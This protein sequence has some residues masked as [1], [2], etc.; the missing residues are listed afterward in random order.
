M[1][2]DESIFTRNKDLSKSNEAQT[3][4]PR[5]EIF[6]RKELFEGDKTVEINTY[7]S[8]T[9]RRLSEDF[10]NTRSIKD[11]LKSLEQ[12]FDQAS[13]NSDKDDIQVSVKQRLQNFMKLNDADN[14][15][16]NANKARPK[17]NSTY[18]LEKSS[19]TP[20]FDINTKDWSSIN[21]P[22]EHKD[23][24]NV[25][26]KNN[27]SGT[28]EYQLNYIPSTSSIELAGLSSDREDSGIQ[29]ADVSCSVSQADDPV[30]TD[31]ETAANTIPNC[32]EK[33]NQETKNIQ[34]MKEFHE[35]PVEKNMEVFQEDYPLK[36][37][38]EQDI[39]KCNEDYND[40]TKIT[41][42]FLQYL[43]IDASNNLSSEVQHENTQEQE[44][45]LP[46]DDSDTKS[47][48]YNNQQQN[49]YENVD[50]VNNSVDY[51]SVPKS[52]DYENVVISNNHPQYE[53]VELKNY[54]RINSLEEPIQTVDILTSDFLNNS[55]F[56]MSAALR[57]P[58]KVKPP[59][60][61]P[62]EED[63][64]PMKRMNST[65]RLK[66]EIHLKRSS[67]LGLDEPTDDQ[68]DPDIGLEK[69]PDIS[70]YLQRESKLE[71][72]LYKKMQEDRIGNLSKVESQ[73]SGLDIDRGR[74][75]SD[76]WCSSIGDSSTPSH[77]RQDSEVNVLINLF[78]Y[79]LII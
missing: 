1:N 12:S 30:D 55:P 19:S 65:K 48:T 29:T 73:D 59:P 39:T 27:D 3:I 69:P 64:K 4:L 34:L 43:K 67:F 24:D 6:K 72:S 35:E 28:E 42:N 33:L 10:T 70:T 5:G 36:E 68:I 25:N 51:Q 41:E 49:Q 50:I 74:L 47:L 60:P 66:K 7:E 16:N 9:S 61:P 32:I 45:I 26:N 18:L 15:N 75:S 17:R 79:L 13:K 52:A 77:E 14:Q 46:V 8:N 53:N 54:V 40:I 71:K 31:L 58:P 76:T 37:P 56:I 23:F 57:E 38:V 2:V 63:E 20:T 62:P 11:R 44:K 78:I 21:V 22:Q